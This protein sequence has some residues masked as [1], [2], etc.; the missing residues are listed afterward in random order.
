V[1]RRS[2]LVVLLACTALMGACVPPVEPPVNTPPAALP[3]AA[4]STQVQPIATKVA[5]SSPVPTATAAAIASAIPGA[6]VATAA[7]APS[8][9]AS[10]T[11]TAQPTEDPVV[12][13]ALEL[14]EPIQRTLPIDNGGHGAKADGQLAPTG[15]DEWLFEGAAGRVLT[16]TVTAKSPDVA[17]G[18]RDDASGLIF[19]ER[20]GASTF[21]VV[22]PDDDNYRLAVRNWGSENAPYSLAVTI[23]P[24]ASEADR[25]AVEPDAQFGAVAGSAVVLP[26][27][28]AKRIQFATGAASASVQSQLAGRGSDKWALKA[29]A[30]Q[31]LNAALSINSGQAILMITGADGTVLISDHAGATQ[32]SGRLPLT[33][34]YIIDVWSVTDTPV[35]YALTVGVPPNAPA[36]QRI[37]FPAGG[38]TASVRGTITGHNSDR[39]LIKVLAGQTLSAKLTFT[40]GQA[41]LVLYGADGTVLLSDHAGATQWSGRL[42]STQDYVIDVRAVVDGQTGYSL[43][44]TVP[45]IASPAPAPLPQPVAQRI[46]FATGGTST[47]VRGTVPANNFARWV[48]GAR[49]GQTM[50]VSIAPAGAAVLVIYGADG[51]V[52]LSDHAGASHWAG[53]LPKTQDYVIDVKSTGSAANY[54]LNVAIAPH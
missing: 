38:T 1:N 23:G 13:P 31:T 20:L 54:T 40:S 9:A 6:P 50:E 2:L 7:A 14:G 5:I 3:V 32:W 37:Q 16:M 42:P 27:P 49:A 12:S 46:R 26:P 28:A 15:T 48:L 45:P 35:A 8:A 17:L 4:P 51:N 36:P 21:T 24:E 29:L 11:K 10:P 34:D 41:I 53:A 33:Q 39:R 43:Q 19:D 18:L 25:F 44:V 47:T 30:G 52:L 22:L